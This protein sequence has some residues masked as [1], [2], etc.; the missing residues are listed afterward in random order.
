[1][2][3]INT[4]NGFAL[5]RADGVAVRELPRRL[6]A[7]AVLIA[8]GGEQGVSRER[9]LDL[10]W[11]DH[12]PT[13]ARHA[14]TQSL[15]SLR[16][17]IGGDEAILGTSQLTFNPELVGSD[18]AD[19][20]AA[21]R[22]G[23]DA[24]AVAVYRGPFLDGFFV[25][26]AAEL[27]HWISLRR[28]EYAN[29]VAQKLE[30]L[31][32]HAEAAGDISGAAAFWRQRS[33]IDPFDATVVLSLMR[34]LAESGKGAAA[35]QQGR[36]YEKLVAQEPDLTPDARVAEL[37]LAIAERRVPAAPFKVGAPAIGE[38]PPEESARSET[39][40]QLANTA[41]SDETGDATSASAA[42]TSAETGATSVEPAP[43][44]ASTTATRAGRDTVASRAIPPSARRRR[45]MAA[46]VFLALTAALVLAVLNA[47]GEWRGKGDPESGS[48]PHA[49]VAVLPFR[50]S[51]ADP[52]VAFLREGMVDLL[53][54]AL[55]EGDSGAVV[56]AGRLMTAWRAGGAPG[57]GGRSAKAPREPSVDSMLRFAE[58]LGA[59]QAVTGAAVGNAQRLILTASL[60]DVADG[61]RVARASAHG[62][63]DSLPRL[64][65]RLAV[66][67]VAQAAGEGD[68][69][70]GHPSLEVATLR[71]YLRGREAQR[72]GD[73]RGALA[74]YASAVHHDSTF[75]SAALGMALAADWLEERQARHRGLAL[76]LARRGALTQRERAQLEAVAGTRHP[77]PWSEQLAAW[78]RA[79]VIAPEREELWTELGRRLLHDGGAAGVVRSR[80]RARRA[81]ERALALNPA[82]LPARRAMLTLMLAEGDSTALQRWTE[83]NPIGTDG[84]ARDADEAWHVATGMRDESALLRFRPALDTLDDDALRRV[85]LFGI[86]DAFQVTD[87]RRAA[88]LRAARA[89]VGEAHTDALLAEH[90]YALTGGRP[91]EARRI[92]RALAHEPWANGAHLRLQVLDALYADGDSA[93]AA[94]AA[95][96]LAVRAARP[97]DGIPERHTVQLADLCVSQQWRV[98]NGD[99]SGV[100]R[101]ARQLQ[102]GGEARHFAPVAASGM[103]CATLL[104]AVAAVRQ[105][106]PRAEELLSH[107][108]SLS[109][110]GPTAGDLRHYVPLAVAR[111]RMERGEDQAALDAVRRRSYARE[112]PRYLASALLLESELATRLGDREGARHALQHFL[113]LRATHEEVTAH[114]VVAARQRLQA[115]ND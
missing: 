41:S 82:Y 58:S 47:A 92:L 96:Q 33:A 7:L 1:M 28:D 64:A 86:H 84:P 63:V 2:L 30:R 91:A 66:Q 50:I 31:A 52:D 99:Y 22:A 61:R 98:W 43:H 46:S 72:H 73:W 108:E 36:I 65:R 38:A 51:G 90:A 81:L 14:L 62:P 3:Q 12:D 37:A 79:T 94:E 5:L 10:L 56:D 16:R 106:S 6:A 18:L 104:E 19:F 89:P 114:A 59:R 34:L 9:M 23:D 112:W 29:R 111:L 76:A 87:G 15:Y 27:E 93:A 97:T 4:F 103:A 49:T 71:D 68:V 17:A 113:A 24:T 80:D 75:A 54:H 35:L 95:R 67:L 55:E 25:S 115:L 110:A 57:A 70:Q 74:E 77:A 100:V 105:R 53:V 8:H 83:G 101:I 13:R 39:S 107:I 45:R 44:G 88:Q 102:Q 26:G 78:E 11:S 85:A 42:G 109:L 48:E 21:E 20:A 60:F 40:L 69:A 32:I